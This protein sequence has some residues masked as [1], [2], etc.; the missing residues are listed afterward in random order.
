MKDN[1]LLFPGW[2]QD[3]CL[4]GDYNCFNLWDKK[5]IEP[6]KTSV[7]YLLGHSMGSYPALLSWQKN[8]D[9]TVI[10]FNP[11]INRIGPIKIIYKFIVMMFVSPGSIKAWKGSVKWK[12]LL[13]AI[14]NAILFRKIDILKIIKEIP[15]G[16]LIIIKG[17][18]DK[19]FCD[20]AAV[21]TLCNSKIG[22]IELADTNHFWS[23]QVDN[24]VEQL[25]K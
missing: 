17:K 9:A 5:Y 8:P 1:V 21:V 12:Y 16:K 3:S 20:V 4:Y 15:R 10:L 19:Y 13:I 2:M 14:K 24:L 7:K 23:P 22:F 11:L 6:S 18:D 25:I